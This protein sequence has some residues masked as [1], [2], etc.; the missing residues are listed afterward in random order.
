MGAAARRLGTLALIPSTD[1]KQPGRSVA[2]FRAYGTR[3]RGDRMV[4]DIVDA[5]AVAL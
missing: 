2:T 5:G 3:A 4:A 1:L